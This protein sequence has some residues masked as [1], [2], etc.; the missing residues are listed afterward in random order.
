MSLCNF[1]KNEDEREQPAA[2]GE[3]ASEKE[4]TKPIVEADNKQLRELVTSLHEK[5]QT[6]SLEVLTAGT[7]ILLLEDPKNTI[8][9]NGLSPIKNQTVLFGLLS[10][11]I[12]R[13]ITVCIPMMIWRTLRDN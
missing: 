10:Y 6:T 8:T 2:T 13:F 1:D 11:L 9:S 4:Q 5:Q 3:K 12:I 7:M